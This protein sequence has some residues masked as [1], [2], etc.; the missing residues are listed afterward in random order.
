[1]F[2]LSLTRRA[3]GPSGPL[4]LAKKEAKP[5]VKPAA[6]PVAKP[7]AKA[8]KAAPKVSQIFLSLI[9]SYSLFI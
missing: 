9:S 6:K 1:M 5:A 8:T 4:K 2:L 7:A 3:S